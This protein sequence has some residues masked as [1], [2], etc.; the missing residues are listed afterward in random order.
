MLQN[1]SNE[2]RGGK[3][4][5]V[6]MTV[7]LTVILI[8]SKYS[9]E[10]LMKNFIVSNGL[11]TSVGFTNKVGDKVYFTYSIN[12]EIYYGSQHSPN[13]KNE[14]EKSILKDRTFPL[15]ID[16]TNFSKHYMLFDSISFVQY[17]LQYP[18]SLR[19][20]QPYLK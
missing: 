18:D 16:S 11:V 15:V 2:V 17:G 12:H 14:N 6:V 3:I 10:S 1:N 9:S 4:A 7:I 5:I 13:F 8:F 20:L 19:W